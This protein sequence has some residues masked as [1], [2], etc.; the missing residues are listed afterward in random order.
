MVKD[1][2]LVVGT[3]HCSHALQT[4]SFYK[5]CVSTTPDCHV[6]I[7]LHI[8]TGKGHQ[9]IYKLIVILRHYKG[10]WS[11]VRNWPILGCKWEWSGRAGIIM[12]V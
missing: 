8:N 4:M 2:S 10:A 3:W 1:F 5:P 9:V 7:P 12:R 11:E 6:L